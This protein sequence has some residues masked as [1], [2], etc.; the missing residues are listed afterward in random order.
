[1]MSVGLASFGEVTDE[2][3][4]RKQW[5]ANA[6]V[7]AAIRAISTD[8]ARLKLRVGPDP[9]RREDYDPAHPLAIMLGPPPGGPNP[10][11]SPRRL[12]R[13]SVA[14][15][16][17]LGRFAWELELQ[18]DE[19]VAIWP[20]VARHLTPVRAKGGSQWFTGYKYA[21]GTGS[22][23]VLRPEQ[24]LYHW[25]PHP[26]DFREPVSALDAASLDV[27]VMVSQDRYDVAFLRNDS[28]PATIVIHEEIADDAER[29]AFRSQYDGRH[30]GPDNAGKTAF[31][32]TQFGS[33]LSPSEALQ[34]VTVGMSQR[35]S[36]ALER[37]AAK[38][39]SVCVALGVPLGRLG[40]VSGRT[41][42]NAE[43]E[44]ETYWVNTILPL[45]EELADT[46]NNQLAPRI[47]GGSDLCWWDYTEVNE[48]REEPVIAFPTLVEA[49]ATG[50]LTRAEGREM[51]GY[52]PDDVTDEPGDDSVED[53][54]AE[55]APTPADVEVERTAPSV[56]ERALER[57][58][59]IAQAVDVKLTAL[60][61][62]FERRF[63]SL[64]DAQE[65]AVLD[66]LQG[67]RGVS[68]HRKGEL[69]AEPL[70]DRQFWT[71]R[72]AAEFESEIAAVVTMAGTDLDAMLDVY[73]KYGLS[74]DLQAPYVQD[75]IRTRANQLAGNVTA[76]TYRNIQEALA[77]GVADGDSIPD[78]A[79]R[80]EGLFQQTYRNRAV[81]VARTEVIAA[82]N[83]G[84]VT[85]ALGY[86]PSVV[87]GTEWITQ[88]DGRTRQHHI[89]AD[90]QVIPAGDVFRVNGEAMAYPGDPNASPSNTVRC[91]CTVGHLTPEQFADRAQGP[92]VLRGAESVELRS[93]ERLVVDAALGRI[94]WD[95]V[96]AG[97][98][99]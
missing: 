94:S 73:A 58:R 3:R 87:A 20:L 62:T 92:V 74:F 68:A 33:N 38:L 34:V 31:L 27:E 97:V 14:Q 56:E 49:V 18:G 72:T 79:R 89:S 60:E 43:R 22:D 41:Y 83:G 69:R 21:A 57:R 53:Q 5:L 47:G 51:L 16:V 67:N 8:L 81:A 64:L 96:I 30:R 35:E 85:T 36:Q 11:T 99:S 12:W 55:P 9:D 71:A 59:R 7:D 24:V 54:P 77:A 23:K 1:M 2:M 32:E 37:Y 17:A 91:R 42:A 39:R 29:E 86:G 6:Y 98:G 26:D 44:I 80:I 45:A 61:H 13:W 15:Y 75:F 25:N 66:R 19:P 93:V 50:L 63:Q 84:S 48:L 65:R 40:D 82:Y 52:D 90:G 76:T 28:K 4:V 95:A 78:L 70:F 46:V 10:V 88:I